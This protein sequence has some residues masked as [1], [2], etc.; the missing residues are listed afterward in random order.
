V[1]RN[2]T[3]RRGRAVLA[4]KEKKNGTA[5]PEEG[6]KRGEKALPLA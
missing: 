5:H 2:K 4:S 6:K 3:H 1:P